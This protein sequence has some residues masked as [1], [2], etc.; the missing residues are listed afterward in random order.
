MSSAPPRR[1]PIDSDTRECSRFGIGA[2]HRRNSVNSSSGIASA[3]RVRGRDRD[4]ARPRIAR[5][6]PSRAVS[7]LRGKAAFGQASC[8]RNFAVG[9]GRAS[10]AH[11]PIAIP[12]RSSVPAS[13]NAGTECSTSLR[14]RPSAR[15]RLPSSRLLFPTR[16]PRRFRSEAIT[17]CSAAV[18]AG[19]G[20]LLPR[21]LLRLQT[22]TS[23]PRPSSRRIRSIR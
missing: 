3:S 20:A 5:D 22:T 14:F 2:S 18:R 16:Q 1:C 6:A 7:C 13:S 8:M 9:P 10:R 4:D 23:F 17:A 19:R 12:V 11:L 15:C 21:D